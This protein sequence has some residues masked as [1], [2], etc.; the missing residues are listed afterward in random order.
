MHGAGGWEVPRTGSL[1]CPQVSGVLVLIIRTRLYGSLALRLRDG[2]C[3]PELRRF[4]VLV[5]SAL[6]LLTYEAPLRQQCQVMPQ[7]N[8]TRLQLSDD[9]GRILQKLLLPSLGFGRIVY[10]RLTI[11]RGEL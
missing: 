1:G 9:R 4:L 7:K 3:L 6:I 5:I 8:L 10:R 11:K 2:V